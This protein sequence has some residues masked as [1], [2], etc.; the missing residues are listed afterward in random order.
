MPACYFSTCPANLLPMHSPD[1][2]YWVAIRHSRV[3]LTLR[4]VSW[5]LCGTATHMHLPKLGL[6]EDTSI[7]RTPWRRRVEET[8]V[9]A[10]KNLSSIS[11][12][13]LIGGRQTSE[14]V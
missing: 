1:H 7:E 13:A 4:C 5:L 12:C 14:Q 8:D 6:D 2:C 9:I 11:W 10:T 3:T